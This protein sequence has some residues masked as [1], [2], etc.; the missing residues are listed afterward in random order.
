MITEEHEEVF[1]QASES[2][3]L[4]FLAA[5]AALVVTALV[6]VGY[7][8]VRNRHAQNNP[9]EAAAVVEPKLPAQA[10]IAVDEPLLQGSNTVLGG[11][12]KNV[13]ND[14]L[15][16]V[17]VE[18]ELRRRRDGSAERKTVNLNPASLGPSEEGRY[19]VQLKAQDYVAAK[20]VGLHAG[21]DTAALRYSLTAG[22]KRPAERL[23]P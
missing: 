12:V 14:R 21:T 4:K 7:A 16:N 13:S 3:S 22:A 20:V 19:S 5:I 17:S 6:F 18:L 9:T 1:I 8:Y 2:S 23:E 11:A 15:D 10:I